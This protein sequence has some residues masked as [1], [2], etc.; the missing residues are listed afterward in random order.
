M[1]DAAPS[2]SR[3]NELQPAGES[4]LRS[5]RRGAGWRAPGPL[6]KLAAAV[7]QSPR[8][9]AQLKLARDLQRKA[10]P[11]GQMDGVSPEAVR[12]SPVQRA[13]APMPAASQPPTVQ[14]RIHVGQAQDHA[15]IAPGLAQLKISH[16]GT[17]YQ[18]DSKRPSWKS[19]LKQ[20]ILDELG[21]NKLPS[22]VDRA[23]KISADDIQNMLG[24][25]LNGDIG[26]TDLKEL[27]D[28]LYWNDDRD[29]D[30]YAT[31]KE[32]RN[33]MVKS[34]V[35][36]DKVFYANALY[37]YLFN[38]KKNVTPGDASSNRANQERFDARTTASPLG[39]HTVLTPD[40]RSIAAA[41]YPRDLLSSPRF[42]GSEIGS[43]HLGSTQGAKP[44]GQKEWNDEKKNF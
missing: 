34:T 24:C 5:T 15:A 11:G 16:S 44:Y 35:I 42:D 4:S 30:D 25:Y 33:L 38:S 37:G 40:T 22:S 21:A 18:V 27:T 10:Q 43:S 32:N 23:H 9:Q 7:N 17:E 31:M 8:V 19:S 28:V 20:H 1:K 26:L 29:K 41:Y 3:Q 2:V 13:I 12:K 14:R 6:A 36:T 39:Q